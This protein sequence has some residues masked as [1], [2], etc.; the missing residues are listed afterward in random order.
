MLPTAC[1]ELHATVK[2]VT[3]AGQKEE[4]T[5][6]SPNMSYKVC[7]ERLAFSSQS[8]RRLFQGRYQIDNLKFLKMINNQPCFIPLKFGEDIV[9]N[10]SSI[11]GVSK[12][13][14]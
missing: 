8:S 6:D 2:S 3:L 7:V 13:R 14:S 12:N 10:L 11:I 9:Y 5:K 1:I 4:P